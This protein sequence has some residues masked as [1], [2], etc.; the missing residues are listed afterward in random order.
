MT[1]VAV[2]HKNHSMHISDQ[3]KQWIEEDIGTGDISTECTVPKDLKAKGIFLCKEDGVVSGIKVVEQVFR[4]IDA[5]LS[6]S[7]NVSDGSSVSK[8]DVFG[9]IEGSA[10]SIIKG[11]RTALNILQRMSGIS[12]LA[13]LM[14]QRANKGAEQCTVFSN[15][16]CC[17]FDTRKT[18]PGLRS[19]DKYAVLSGGAVNHRMGLYDMIMVKDNHIE[20]AGGIRQAIEG[21][22]QYKLRHSSDQLI[23]VEIETRTLEEVEQVLEFIDEIDIVMLDNMTTVRSDGSLDTLMLE[24]AV[25]LLNGTVKTEASGNVTLDSVEKIAMTGVDYIS[26]GALTHSVKALDISLKISLINK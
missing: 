13:S 10:A 21:I 4:Q 2:K 11:E 6:L 25:K 18:I 12:S 20:A 7:W 19:L 17:I 1:L 24:T 9:T 16:K 3:V 26:S 23:S 5:S 14:V 15:H 22:R 8:G